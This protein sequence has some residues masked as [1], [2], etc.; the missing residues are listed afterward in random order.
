MAET[1][2]KQFRGSLVKADGERVALTASEAE[3]LWERCEQAQKARAERLPDAHACLSA[4][5]EAESRLRELGWSK[6]TYCP[7]DGTQFAV[8]QVGSTGMWA[9][10]WS[11]DGDKAPFATGYVIAADCVHR[12]SE[13]YFKPINKLT[14]DERAHMEKCDQDV[15]KWIDRIAT[16]FD[17]VTGGDA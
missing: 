8:C 14:D 16:S 15:A 9:G 5:S 17:A 4:L 6:G 7:R 11:E 12:P 13:V 1:N 2:E 3:A 10:V